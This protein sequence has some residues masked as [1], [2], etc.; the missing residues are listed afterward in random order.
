[1]TF[2][3]NLKSILNPGGFIFFKYPTVPKSTGTK[4]LRLSHLQFLQKKAFEKLAKIHNLDFVN[5][6]S[7]AY[8]F[9]KRSFIP[10]SSND[11]YQMKSSI[12]SIGNLKKLL[13]RYYQV[14]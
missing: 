7:S 12:F 14:N 2:S 6:S 3:V 10:K 5:F 8:S 11:Y 9:D 1:M 4:T 13:K